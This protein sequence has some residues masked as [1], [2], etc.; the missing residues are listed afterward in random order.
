MQKWA[1]NLTSS[2]SSFFC[3]DDSLLFYRA[4]LSDIQ[5]IQD[6]LETDERASRQQINK[7]KTNLFSSKAVSMER[8]NEIKN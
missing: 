4:Q 3:A 6:I 1:K 8:K 5:T 2:S 7:E